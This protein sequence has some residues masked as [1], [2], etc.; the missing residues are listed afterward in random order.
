MRGL[1]LTAAAGFSVGFLV[2]ANAAP[3]APT[4]ASASP[5]IV[6]AAAHCGW[7]FH[8]NRYRRCVPNGYRYSYRAR[9][10]WPGYYGGGWDG[11]EPWNR[12]SPTDHVARQLNRQ[13]LGR[14][15]YG[16]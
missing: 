11:H 5:A 13:E 8:V 15:Y 2:A 1:A 12:P 10:Y 3:L 16:Y 7:G 6:Q 14:L 9:S 4:P